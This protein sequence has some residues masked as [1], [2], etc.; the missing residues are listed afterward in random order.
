[1]GNVRVKASG[2]L[3]SDE[4]GGLRKLE[5]T[6]EV[7]DDVHLIYVEVDGEDAGAFARTE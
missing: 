2:P 3:N 6:I 7:N 4:R 5:Q 1:M